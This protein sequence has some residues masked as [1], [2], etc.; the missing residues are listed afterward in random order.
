MPDLGFPLRPVS[1]WSSSV[2]GIC[3]LCQ[4]WVSPCVRYLDRAAECLV[5][6]YYA[7]SGFSLVSGTWIEQQCL[8]SAY[9]AKSGF[10]LVSGIWM[11]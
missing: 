5:S 9:N 10:S 1:G 7:R 11:K 4:I 2:S 6:A 8:V 3:L